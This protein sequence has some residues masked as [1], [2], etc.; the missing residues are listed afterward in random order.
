MLLKVPSGYSDS[1]ILARKKS[2]RKTVLRAGC[3]I[4][5]SER[6]PAD[7]TLDQSQGLSGLV[8]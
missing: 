4:Y 1:S 2:A 8:D 5:D 7:V 3:H 6:V